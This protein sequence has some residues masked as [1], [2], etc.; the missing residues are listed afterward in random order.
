[1][2]SPFISIIIPTLNAGKD[3]PRFIE[4]LKRQSY[5]RK[6]IE[7]IVADGGSV[8]DTRKIARRYQAKI[9]DNPD[10]WAETGV[11]YGMKEAKGE[12][13]MILAVD[14]FFT[15]KTDIGE[16]VNIFRDKSIFAAFPKQKSGKNDSLFT[17]YI[18]TFT[19]PFNHFI[20][21]KA[22]NAR[23][24]KDIYQVIEHNNI[25]DVYDFSTYPVKPILALAQGFSVR[26]EFIKIRKDQY[27]DITPIYH[28]INNH[29]RIGYIHSVSIIHH[30][31]FGLNHFIQKQMRAIINVFKKRNFGLFHRKDS[32]TFKQ[33]ILIY[34]FPLYGITVIPSLLYAIYQSLVSKEPV[35]LFHPVISFISSVIIIK[36]TA[37]KLMTDPVFLFK[38]G[39]EKVLHDLS[40]KNITKIAFFLTTF[41]EYGGGVE[42]RFTK[43]ANHLSES[44]NFHADVVTLNDQLSRRIFQMMGIYYHRNFSHQVIYKDRIK[45][46]MVQLG[47]AKYIKAVDF[48]NLREILSQYDIIYS[49]NEVLEA[50]ILKFLLGY[51]RLPPVIFGCHTSV[52]YPNPINFH[53]KIHNFLYNSS[54]YTF[55]ASGV[56]KFIALNPLDR[57]ILTRNFPSENIHLV[58]SIFSAE[59]F[60]K[61]VSKYRLDLKK[62]PQKYNILWAGRITAQKGVDDLVKIISHFNQSEFKDKIIWNIAGDGEERQTIINLANISGNVNFLGYLD[63]RYMAYLYKQNDLFICT[64]QWESFGNTIL[65][66]QYMNLPV[67]SYDIPGP[68][69]I[70]IE[71]KTGVLVNNMNQF[72]MAIEKFA[73]GKI[74]MKNISRIIKGKFHI[75]EDYEIL[76]KIINQIRKPK[77]R[78]NH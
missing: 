17:K 46:I 58:R 42:H 67:I 66:A 11:Y 74:I 65:E 64:S 76:Y 10:V 61:S 29:Y 41:L 56:V 78:Y 62:D 69:S 60:I 34:L 3:L 22:A 40:G 45:D 33:K 2:Y 38:F 23:T 21:G 43:M 19:D 32:L 16:V 15:K 26:R 7:L 70:V 31:V 68:R 48:R 9:V 53:T 75:K 4:A 20:Y 6:K 13:L 27:D 51:S 72:I 50:F 73:A 37:W 71:G 52:Y 24:F 55:L 39:K 49:K 59:D 25:Y 57:K 12:I 5:S 28:L 18:N 54:I 36:E 35:W 77:V 1:M 14:N 30:T 47:N 44:K 63:H 8:D